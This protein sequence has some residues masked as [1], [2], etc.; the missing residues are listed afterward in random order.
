MYLFLN[1]FDSVNRE[2]SDTKRSSI[3]HMLKDCFSSTS[4]AINSTTCVDTRALHTEFALVELSRAFD[5]FR[6]IRKTER[7]ITTFNTLF[8]VLDGGRNLISP[9]HMLLVWTL[10][11]IGPKS[12]DILNRQKLLRFIEKTKGSKFCGS[13][14]RR[15]MF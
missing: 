7:H 9:L 15:K 10:F 1:P 2:P 5:C 13:V 14:C 8:S 11:V 3:E 6:A 12:R 4:C